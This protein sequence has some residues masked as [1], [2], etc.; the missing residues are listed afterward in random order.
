[1]CAPAKLVFKAAGLSAAP[2][3]TEEEVMNF[4]DDVEEQDLIDENQKEMITNI[5]EL[6]EVEAGQI[7]TH[8][9][10]IVSVPAQGHGRPRPCILP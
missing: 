1:M 10:E 8:R 7:M 4:V 6:D 5:F 2:D 3:L 9:T